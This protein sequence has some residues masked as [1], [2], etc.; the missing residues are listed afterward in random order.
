[1]FDASTMNQ[2]NSVHGLQEDAS[3]I[4]EPDPDNPVDVRL[5]ASAI[6]LPLRKARWMQ[7]KTPLFLAVEFNHEDIV[8]FLLRVPQSPICQATPRC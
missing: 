6:A 8:R 7:A 3:R 2:T 1:M 5:V 4:D